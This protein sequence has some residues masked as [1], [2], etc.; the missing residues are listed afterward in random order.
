MNFVHVP[1]RGKDQYIF[2]AGVLETLNSPD[3]SREIDLAER[4][5][6]AIDRAGISQYQI[7]KLTGVPQ[8]VVSEFLS[9]GDLRLATFSRIASLMGFELRQNIARMPR[10]KRSRR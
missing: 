5:R 7:S 2:E 4:L 10:K 6:K 9:G 8:S 3:L 1:G